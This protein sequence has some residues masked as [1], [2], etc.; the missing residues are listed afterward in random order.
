MRKTIAGFAACLTLIGLAKSFAGPLQEPR[1]VD[2]DKAGVMRVRDTTTAAQAVAIPRKAASLDDENEI[3]GLAK[4]STPETVNWQKAYTLAVIRARAVGGGPMQTLDPAALSRQA[5]RLGVADFGRF[6]DDFFARGAFR[7]PAKDL[8]A[9]LY[10]LQQIDNARHR[11]AVLE[12]LKTAFPER[13]RDQSSGLSRL[14]VDTVFAASVK[15]GEALNHQK[16]QFR[17]ALDALKAALGVPLQAAIIPDR[18]EMAGFLDV[19]DSVANWERNADRHT[20]DL[21][22]IIAQLPELGD[23]IL[24]GQPLLSTIQVDPDRWESSLSKAARLALENRSNRARAALDEDAR[25][26]LELQIRRSVRQL[27]EMRLAY[28]DAERG[29][30]YAVRLK[31]Q[32]FERLHGPSANGFSQRSAIVEQLVAQVGNITTIEDRLAELWTT[33]RAERLT[34]YRELGV[35]PYSNWKAFYADLTARRIGA[36]G[37]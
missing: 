11:L 12:G 21:A 30:E 25:V 29:Y 14:D 2:L 3:A 23:V 28:V 8:F 34:L 18:K 33:F 1:P 17:D 36:L 9:L 4:G 35:L 7:D 27:F 24:D 20:E 16:M 32:A 6:R 22:K 5:E 31:D 19:F 37:M 15:A 10:R 26:Q 13:S